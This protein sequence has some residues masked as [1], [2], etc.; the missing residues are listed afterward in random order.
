[1]GI[2]DRSGLGTKIINELRLDLSRDEHDAVYDY[3][4]RRFV[5]LSDET[6]EQLMDSP[7]PQPEG[8]FR[9]VV[10]DILSRG[11]HLE[12]FQG[13]LHRGVGT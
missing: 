9:G 11:G 4:M 3:G 13:E 6:Y 5:G 10:D 7:P 1:M 2:R 12:D 8:Q